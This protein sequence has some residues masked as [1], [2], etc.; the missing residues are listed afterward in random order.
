MNKQIVL[1]FDDIEN[2][3]DRNGLNFLFYWK[4]KYPKFKITLFTI[5]E[6]TSKEI[7]NLVSK[8]DWIEIAQHGWNH[9]SN[10]ECYG[11]DYDTASA[12]LKRGQELGY[13]RYL[14]LLVGQ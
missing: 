6:K 1:D 12:Y 14:K 4:A 5:P 11:W 3:Y 9:E 2:K 8:F 7:L 10:F 13:K